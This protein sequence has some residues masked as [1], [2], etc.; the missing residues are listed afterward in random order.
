M[1]DAIARMIADLEAASEAGD[2]TDAAMN[3]R[4]QKLLIVDDE[5]INIKL[6]ASILEDNSL[7]RWLPP[8]DQTRWRWPARNGLI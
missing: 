2:G 4:P 7:C 3:A 6:L 1:V 5:E 8:A